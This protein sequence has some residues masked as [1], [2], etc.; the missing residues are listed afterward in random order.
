MKKVI[1]LVF[2]LAVVFSAGIYA[3]MDEDGWMQDGMAV[4]TAASTDVKVE[5]TADGAR[6]IISSK[7][8]KDVKAIQEHAAK[9]A[10]MREKMGK[11]MGMGMGMGMMNPHM[12][13][14]M[15]MV[16]GFLTVIWSLMIL[17]IASTTVLV[18]K[19]IISK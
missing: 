18:I 1:V 17:L 4:M 15:G 16:F 10:E 14:K 9:M 19:K 7:N 3:R 11:G 12:Q 8:A 2:V 13:K 6:I 5:N